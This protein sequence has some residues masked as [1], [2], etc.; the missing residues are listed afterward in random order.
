M[1]NDWSA[2]RRRAIKIRFLSN[3][4]QVGA[5]QPIRS[6]YRVPV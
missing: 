6:A 1:E 4:G 5:S 2:Y 3:I